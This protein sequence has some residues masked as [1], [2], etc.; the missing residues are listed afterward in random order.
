MLAH[1]FHQHRSQQFI[2]G[3]A[4]DECSLGNIA[5]ER[6]GV[7]ALGCPAEPMAQL[8]VGVGRVHHSQYTAPNLP[9]V[10]SVAGAF[11]YGQCMVRRKVSYLPFRVKSDVRQRPLLKPRGLKI[12]ILLRFLIGGQVWIRNPMLYPAELHPRN[13]ILLSHCD[14]YFQLSLVQP[15]F[16]LHYS[17]TLAKVQLLLLVHLAG[18]IV[19]VMFI[20]DIV[21][22][23]N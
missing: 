8:R 16:R 7:A 18:G 12:E 11:L 5:H 14:F 15:R 21:A 6:R 2:V 19:K 4:G 20:N 10:W 22:A 3:R 17:K 13:P 9:G 23:K 1:Q